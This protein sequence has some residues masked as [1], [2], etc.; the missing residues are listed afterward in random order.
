[1]AS[2][3][4][5]LQAPLHAQNPRRSLKNS[6]PKPTPH[7]DVFLHTQPSSLPRSQASSRS[8]RFHRSHRSCS[9]A[10]SCPRSPSAAPQP[11]PSLTLSR[12]GRILL[13]QS[14]TQQNPESIMP[15]AASQETRSWLQERGLGGYL[16]VIDAPA[17]PDAQA[18]ARRIHPDTVT[19]NMIRAAL[20][21]KRGGDHEVEIPPSTTLKEY[22]GAYS[23][24]GKAYRTYGG[25]NKAFGELA[26]ILM[27][28]AF[29]HTNPTSMPQNKAAIIISEYE[30]NKIDW[31]IITGEGV[32]VALASFQSGKKLLSVM[33]HFF[34]VLYPPPSLSCPR[35]L[36]SPPQPRKQ[37]EKLLALNQEAWEEPTPPS[38]PSTAQNPTHIS[39]PPPPKTQKKRAF[40]DTCKELDGKLSPRTTSPRMSPLDKK[41]HGHQ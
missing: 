26:R 14:S 20:D 23:I 19:N 9:Q 38:P 37:R 27:E 36:S 5:N 17:H 22:F 35:T 7:T 1:M 3:P 8:Q 11:S 33:T 24:S 29:V 41:R 31:G 40:L 2:T 32:R 25:S 10:L 34:T 30:G 15:L 39:V 28:Y 16:K 21:L 4:K 13:P 6:Y 18:V 12:P